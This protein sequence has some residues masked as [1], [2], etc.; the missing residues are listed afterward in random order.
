[1]LKTLLEY[2]TQHD[3]EDIHS[4]AQLAH[5]GQK[6][7]SG[8]EYFTHPVEVANIIKRLYPGDNRAYLVALLHDTLEDAE[9]VGNITIEELEE[10]IAG[11]ISDRSEYE[12]IIQAVRSLTHEKNTPYT[13]YLLS[14]ASSPLALR[15]K[16]ADMLHNLS[17]SPS[18][19][20]IQKYGNALGAL[21]DEFGGTPPGVSPAHMQK[22]DSVVGE[23]K[24]RELVRGM[25]IN[26]YRSLV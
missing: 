7:R 22:L 13:D 12:Q 2:L 8:E 21:E 9:S 25:L 16:L 5:L 1:M 23:G 11:S 10:M 14:L 24:I 20:Q 19:R 17:S 18:P 6:R 15:V 26:D 3:V 4:T